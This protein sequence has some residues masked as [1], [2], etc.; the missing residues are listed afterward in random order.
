[1]FRACFVSVMLATTA[2]VLPGVV[3]PA[4]ELP[5]SNTHNAQNGQDLQGMYLKYY[6]ERGQLQ[7]ADRKSFLA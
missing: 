4:S 6:Q 7:Q 2:F 5:A 3:F 1:M